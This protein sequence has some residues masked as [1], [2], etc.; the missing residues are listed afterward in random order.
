MIFYNLKLKMDLNKKFKTKRDLHS[1]MTH[2]RK[3][4][5]DLSNPSV[6]FSKHMAAEG[7]VL[8]HLIL[9]KN[10]DRLEKIFV[11]YRH[12]SKKDK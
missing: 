9:S 1:Y 4:F 8:P 12:R 10:L 3:Y 6:I 11:M 2:R 7:Q 5:P